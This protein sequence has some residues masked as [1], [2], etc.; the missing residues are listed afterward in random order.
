MFVYF[1]PISAVF[2][3]RNRAIPATPCPNMQGIS[4][5]VD[6]NPK[7]AFLDSRNKE[8]SQW[9]TIR[10][11]ASIAAKVFLDADCLSQASCL[12]LRSL[13]CRSLAQVQCRL[14]T[15]WA[16][17]LQSLNLQSKRHLFHSTKPNQ[18]SRTATGGRFSASV[19]C[20]STPQIGAV[21]C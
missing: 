16:N 19:F 15:A 9:Q 3:R 12:W 10:T 4:A 21:S 2:G 8:I 13:L 6:P 11:Q 14:R 18:N 7:P 20:M 1:Q 17:S 5:Y